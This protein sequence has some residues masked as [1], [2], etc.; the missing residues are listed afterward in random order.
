M[1]IKRIKMNWKK[2]IAMFFCVVL[3]NGVSFGIY[4]GESVVAATVGQQ[5]LQPETGWQRIDYT[6]SC[7][8]YNGAWINMGSYE[9]I[10]VNASTIKF[11]FTGSKLRLI[12]TI[13]PKSGDKHSISIDGGAVE[14]FSTR[15]NILSSALFYEKTGLT[16]GLHT[17]SITVGAT[18]TDYGFNFIGADVESVVSTVALNKTSDSIN[19]GQTDTLT[20]TTT[21]P[22]IG[23]TWTSSDST[24]ATVDNT[25]KVTAVKAGV[26]TIKATTTDGSNLSATCSVTVTQPGRAILRITMVNNE[27]KEFD[28]S[29][30]EISKF[31]DWYNKNS[32]PSYSVVETSNIKPFNSR[33]QYIAHDKIASFE[34]NQ[35]T[36]N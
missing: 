14:Y 4:G 34:V 16:P 35:Y 1:N 33:T 30:D 7:F 11:N 23:V 19:V 5:L 10:S 26:A 20:A 21:P 27:V 9:S 28:V 12:G 6:N 13:S 3:V 22:G 15:G 32:S 36:S 2:I 31:V 18:D 29:S 8:Q 24:I 17:V 25:G